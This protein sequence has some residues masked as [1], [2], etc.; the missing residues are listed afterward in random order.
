MADDGWSG[1]SHADIVAKL[2]ALKADGA[3]NLGNAWT[4]VYTKVSDAG[5]KLDLAR[6]KLAT[7]GFWTGKGPAAAL[8]TLSAQVTE[9][10]DSE[11]GTPALAGKMSNALAQDG[12]VLTSA[13]HVAQAHPELGSG[14]P[15][16]RKK[17]ELEAIRSEA[18][19]LY[20]T[21][22]E[23]KRP[24]ITDNA[25]QPMSGSM[26]Q[27]PSGGA[28]GGNTGG[29]VSGSGN[30]QSPS[31]ADG[32]ASKD[33]KPQLAGGDGQQGGAGQ[34]QGQGGGQGGGSG[35]GTPGGGTGSGGASSGFGA[36]S[37]DSGTG[38]PIGSTTAAGYSPSATGTG[39]GAGPGSGVASG[40][41]SGLRGGGLSGGATAGG[42]SGGVNPAGVSAA[43]VRGIGGPM[44]MMGGGA[45]GARGKGEDE[46]EH[47]TPEWL[48]NLDNSE[49]W[50]GERR[51][52]IPGGVLG[53][54][55]AAED[56]DKQAL[57]AEKRRFKSIGWNVKFSDED[58]DKNGNNK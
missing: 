14:A 29:G 43:G 46:D 27:G 38:L 39:S 21:P 51:T 23:A 10:D 54:F 57:E 19:R 31:G 22:L 2:S 53:D 32:L 52:F 18:Q 56:A 7:E 24:E 6:R 42:G 8:R 11:S 26:P 1:R 40:G 35:G 48:K 3:F 50:L 30:P 25:G 49:E 55:K 16:E 37:K 20:T 9:F 44:G 34:G 17:E 28:G 4:E 41:L 33:T 45:H 12:E 5:D 47:A 36:G 13:H 15:T 58:D